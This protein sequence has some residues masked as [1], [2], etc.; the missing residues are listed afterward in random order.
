MNSRA[1]ERPAAGALGTHM[2]KNHRRLVG[3]G[4]HALSTSTRLPQAADLGITPRHSSPDAVT[5]RLVLTGNGDHPMAS[6]TFNL[7][8]A[9]VTISS[10]LLVKPAG[11]VFQRR[12]A[13]AQSRFGQARFP[14]P[15]CA[16]QSVLERLGSLWRAAGRSQGRSH[17]GR[18]EGSSFVTARLFAADDAINVDGQRSL[19]AMCHIMS[20]LRHRRNR[21]S[22]PSPQNGATAG[23]YPAVASGI[24]FSPAHQYSRCPVDNFTPIADRG[25]RFLIDHPR[26]R[27]GSP[28]R[29]TAIT[30][31]RRACGDR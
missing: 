26:R 19:G 15:G 10:F 16:G 24:C 30:H 11:N 18:S 27:S 23:A 6:R 4:R 12:L 17:L 22:E 5:D 3:R 25:H 14:R 7:R 13:P 9:N 28:C 8:R 2:R 29:Y 21:R 20:F 31:L 1:L